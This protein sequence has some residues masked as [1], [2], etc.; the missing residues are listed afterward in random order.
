MALYLFTDCADPFTSCLI[1]SDNCCSGAQESVAWTAEFDGWYYLGVDAYTS[2]GCLVTV[3]IADPVG[4]DE[5]N[6]G[7]MKSMFR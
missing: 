3:T 1:G 2:A 6:W 7:S 4:A 5:T